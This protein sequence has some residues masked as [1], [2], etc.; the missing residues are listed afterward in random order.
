MK[1]ARGQ[2]AEK[3]MRGEISPPTLFLKVVAYGCLSLT[4]NTPSSNFIRKL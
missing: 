1:W 2:R 3:G 4:P